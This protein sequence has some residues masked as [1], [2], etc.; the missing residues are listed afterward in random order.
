MNHILIEN[1]ERWLQ[2]SRTIGYYILVITIVSY[3]NIRCR[4]MVAAMQNI[5]DIPGDD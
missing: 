2:L 1:V 3:S 5:K 4:Q